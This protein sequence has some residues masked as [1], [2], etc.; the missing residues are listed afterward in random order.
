M[1]TLTETAAEAVRTLVAGTDVDDETGGLRIFTGEVTPQGAAALEVA[2]VNEP[3]ATDAAIDEAGAHVFLESKVAGILDD[4]VLDAS[5]AS[6]RVRF[7]VLDRG[8][9]SDPDSNGGR[10]A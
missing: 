8:T 7:E 9:M 3:E 5:V 4:K 6:G 10:P 1:L 2:L